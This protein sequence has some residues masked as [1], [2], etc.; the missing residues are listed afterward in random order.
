MAKVK[1]L[2]GVLDLEHVQ[3]IQRR[4]RQYLY[5]Q[6]PGARE[7]LPD[8]PS[9]LL[10]R[11]GIL[12]NQS[13]RQLAQ[14]R[15][16]SLHEIISIYKAHQKFKRL[17]LATREDYLRHLTTL[18]NR[19]GQFL[20]TDIPPAFPYRLLDEYQDRPNT[21]NDLVRVMRLVLNFALQR[22]FV[23]RNVFKGV[24]LLPTGPGYS[25]WANWQLDQFRNCWAPE[26]TERVAF[27]LF[28]NTGQR[29]SDIYVM[30]RRQYNNGMIEVVQLK[31]KERVC[32]PVTRTLL[33]ILAPYV[34]KLDGMGTNCQQQLFPGTL[35]QFSW[36]MRQ[37]VKIA[38]LEG[39][40]LH[41]LRY[42]AAS[43]LHEA[44]CDWLTIG[45]ITGHKTAEMVRKYIEKK[46]LAGLAI[47][48]L[49]RTSAK[50]DYIK[51]QDGVNK[52]ANR[53]SDD[54]G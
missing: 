45:A 23:E 15:P 21:A 46:R 11:H 3:V 50:R 44:G 40:T 1:T 5:W 7:R 27:E 41:G 18:E 20:I 31:T 29:R 39:C 9:K 42:T 19:F 13:K 34:A 24:E 25:P 47:E 38:R 14:T 48:A 8:N 22:G 4:G 26:T 32:I 52:T 33:A 28:I 17:A 12:T 54:V 10:K 6:G 36:M 53:N 2:I 49:E 51:P 37:A 30:H 35:H 43:A 16:G